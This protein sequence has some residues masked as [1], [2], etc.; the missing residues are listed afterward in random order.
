MAKQFLE[1]EFQ[2]KGNKQ[3][4]NANSE[5]NLAVFLAA[6]DSENII[7]QILHRKG[8]IKNLDRNVIVRT[9]NLPLKS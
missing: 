6:P 8:Q 1:L 2:H 9:G 3:T 4:K 7:F 5:Q